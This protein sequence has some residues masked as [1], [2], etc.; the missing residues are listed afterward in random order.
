MR[1]ITRITL[2]HRGRSI[3]LV[4]LASAVLFGGAV[5]A[6]A[7]ARRSADAV[8]H[9]LA[10]STPEDVFVGPAED[11][12]LDMH[13]VDSLP[14]VEAAAYEAY[15]AMVPIAPDGRPQN[16]LAGSI[17]PYLYARVDGPPGTIN[18]LRIVQGRDL[19]PAAPFEVVI[20][21][22]LAAARG[23]QVDSH[24]AMA[25][26]APAQ[27]DAIFGSETGSPDIAPEGP[28]LDLTVV[29]VARMPVDIHPGEEEH[30]TTF[31]GTKDIYLTPALFDRLG[32][33]MIVFGGPTADT[34][35]ALRLVHGLADLDTFTDH[36]RA[37]PGG[38]D[39]LVDV[40]DSDALGSVI[41][42]RRAVSVETAALLALAALL[43]VSGLALVGHALARLARDT[44]DDLLV[45]R[46][47][48][49][50]PAELRAAAAAPG[51]VAVGLGA[52]GA[53]A[54]AVA[55]SAFTPIGLARDAETHV[56]ID[57]DTLVLAVGIL[58]V[59]VVG[60][61]LTWLGVRRTVRSVGRP[62]ALPRPG[63]RSLADR[64]GAMGA[65]FGPTVGAR[66][67]THQRA[68]GRAPLRSAVVATTLALIVLGAVAT[69]TTSLSHLAGSRAAQGSTWDVSI[70]NLNLS[71]YGPDDYSRLRDDPHVGGF[72]A[73]A[74]PQGRGFVNGADVPLAGIDEVEGGAGPRVLTGRM[75][76]APGEVT[77]GHR[78]ADRLGVRVGD[79]VE[80]RYSDTM[81]DAEVVGTALL[82]PGITPSMLI[83]DGAVVTIDQ[84][85]AIAADQPTNFFLVD[86]KP[87][88]SVDDAIAALQ[89]LWGRNATRPAI[90]A[91]VVNLRRV[92]GVPI[93]LAAA[94][95]VAAVALV[96]AA[97]VLSVRQRRGDIGVLR[98]VGATRRQ[99]ASALT[100]QVLWLYGAAAVVGVPLGVVAGRVMWREVADGVG[101]ILGPS[102]PAGVI[103]LIAVTG[104]AVVLA[105]VVVPARSATRLSP[106]TALRT[107]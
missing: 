56:G 65:P 3:V 38:R 54:V 82:G 42:A 88:T 11:S 89:P 6:A 103:A 39:A 30:T 70:G 91:D 72:A 34:P 9:A 67:A 79:R 12:A 31:G 104:L 43:A 27:Q 44:T 81:V 99:L 48:G 101:A 76:T 95:G 77:L 75:P 61:T 46:A 93:A 83:G 33:Q 22:E 68:S 50:R 35:Q 24:L 14:E 1:A 26:F 5:G 25:T 92:R 8:D 2:A 18:R 47:V 60:A 45:L 52:I 102:V 40:S 41:T 87:G 15:L 69:Y 86:V 51:L 71:D 16:D 36:V 58:V 63:S 94:L 59:A 64:L 7:G 74:A 105:L 19:D 66:F 10:Y 32:D 21:E 73:V 53:L 57:V 49:A 78:S 106:A 84:M 17:N 107:E 97:L 90:A 23:L 4:A 85:K 20:D 29:G 100:W 37:L 96:G 13:A 28:V 62:P 98:A 80:L 55:S